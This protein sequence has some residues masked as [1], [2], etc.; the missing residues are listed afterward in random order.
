MGYDQDFFIL[1]SITTSGIFLSTWIVARFIWQP[2]V[3][4]LDSLGEPEIPYEQKY[5]ITDEDLESEKT[6]T[7]GTIT[8][9]T[10]VGDVILQYSEKNEGF[11][12]WCNVIVPYKYL[13]TVARKYVKHFNCAKLYIERSDEILKTIEKRK[14]IK[15]KP[16][17]NPVFATL[18]TYE[19]K[20]G[21]PAA[22]SANKYRRC[23]KIKEYINKE[24][25]NTTP[26]Q[27]NYKQWINLSLMSADTLFRG[28]A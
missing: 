24:T 19:K 4:H 8:E 17:L 20:L 14:E 12:Y 7:F 15:I 23:G 6:T 3:Q 16:K 11:E 13:E 26:K 9:K 28:C 10:P 25:D 21:P 5:I 18:K 22:Q 1:L 2:W 27:L